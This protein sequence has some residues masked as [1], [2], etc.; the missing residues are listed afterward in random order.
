[1]FSI[2]PKIILFSALD[3]EDPGTSIQNL[4]MAIA[5]LKKSQPPAH[6]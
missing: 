3:Y 4:E 6:G 5:V 1:M 2:F